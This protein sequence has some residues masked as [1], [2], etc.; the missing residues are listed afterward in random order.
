MDKG[1][2]VQ[3]YALYLEL[4]RVNYTAQFVITP[5]GYDE[6]GRFTPATVFRR[7]L[8]TSATKRRWRNYAIRMNND[9]FAA[10]RTTG[11]LSGGLLRASLTDRLAYIVD[12]HLYRLGIT[13]KFRLYNDTPIFVEVTKADLT[14]IKKGDLPTKLWTRIKSSRAALGFP[15]DVVD[16]YVAGPTLLVTPTTATTL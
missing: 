16:A 7:T 6:S 9:S 8:H 3:G 2:D 1:K 11:E 10:V 4:R 12:Q 13:D 5:D 15:E 14:E